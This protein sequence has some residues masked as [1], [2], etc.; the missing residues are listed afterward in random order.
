[1]FH[2][3][4]FHLWREDVSKNVV[5]CYIFL[6]VLFIKMPTFLLF[7]FTKNNLLRY[8]RLRYATLSKKILTISSKVKLLITKHI[9]IIEHFQYFLSA[10]AKLSDFCVIGCT[11]C[12]DTSVLWATYVNEEC[13]KHKKSMND[14]LIQFFWKNSFQPFSSSS[15]ISFSFW[16]SFE[17]FKTWWVHELRFYKNFFLFQRQ[18][19]NDQTS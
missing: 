6:I 7:P 15:T 19:R 8:P 16:I 10:L 5:L 11:N 14:T 4:P 18:R 3:I 9:F 12:K 1:M 13:R 17:W 2:I